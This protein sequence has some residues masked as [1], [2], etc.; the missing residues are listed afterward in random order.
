MIELQHNS[1]EKH[2]IPPNK[3]QQQIPKTTSIA[4]ETLLQT[5]CCLIVN[6]V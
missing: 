5:F 3:I 4:N 6:K 2:Q 1:K